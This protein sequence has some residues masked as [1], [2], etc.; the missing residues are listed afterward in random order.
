MDI[1]V[2][3]SSLHIYMMTNIACGHFAVQER[4]QEAEEAYTSALSLLA[5]IEQASDSQLT[6]SQAR[7]GLGRLY[8]HWGGKLCCLAVCTRFV[9]LAIF[10]KRIR[11]VLC[12]SRLLSSSTCNVIRRVLGT[13]R[14]TN[15]GIHAFSPLRRAAQERQ[16]QGPD[17]PAASR[18]TESAGV[19]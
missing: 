8:W 1:T 15:I 6:A 2:R 7:F 17:E 9:P 11:S 19:L 14:S 4:Y 12:S 3:F 18:A 16:G 13:R 10:L 5:N